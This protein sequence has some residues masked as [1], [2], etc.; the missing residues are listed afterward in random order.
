MVA[1]FPLIWLLF[2]LNSLAQSI[3]HLGSSGGNG[4]KGGLGDLQ[5]PVLEAQSYVSV[6]SHRYA[7]RS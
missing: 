4:P 1:F 2:A 6:L 5:H 7:S 3:K